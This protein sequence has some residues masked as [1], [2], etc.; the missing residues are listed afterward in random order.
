MGAS[1]GHG[2]AVAQAAQEDDAGLYAG[3]VVLEGELRQADHGQQLEV[4]KQPVA[5]ALQR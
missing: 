3:V 4:V 1:S 5:D 2:F